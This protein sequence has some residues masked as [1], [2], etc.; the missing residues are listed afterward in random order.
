M[1]E[2]IGGSR[3][4]GVMARLS[5]RISGWLIAHRLLLIAVFAGIT[6]CLGYRA[7]LLHMDPGFDKSIPLKHSYM[8]TFQQYRETFG[9]ANSVVLALLRKDG[10]IFNADYLKTLEDAT[11][12]VI[13][14]PGVDRAWVKSLF[15]PNVF[16]IG[17]NEEGY[18]AGRIVPSDFKP[19]EA[20]IDEVRR[21]LLLSKE[22]G[23]LVSADYSGALISALLVENDPK[24]GEKLDYVRLA[25]QL[26]VIRAKYSND[27][28]SVHIIGFAK[29]IGD[30][31]VG[32]HD[33]FVFFAITLG[34]TAV[35]LYFF[36][37]SVQIT[38]LAITVALVA[39]IWQLGLV[40][41]VGYGVD[42]LSILVPFLIL[43]IGIS[44]AV[45]M[46]NAW[47]L[48]V[49]KG[50][51]SVEA[52][53]EAFNKLFIPGTTAL[54][55]NAVGFGV[56]ML[57]DIAIIHELGI[58]A[59][60]GV[61]VMVITNKFLLPALLCYARINPQSRKTEPQPIARHWQI[62]SGAAERSVWTFV[63]IAVI[64][65]TA[66]W[67]SR[68]LIVGDST[69]GAPEFYADS[70]Y[71]RDVAAINS[72]FNVAIDELMVVAET[73]E[74]GCVDFGVLRTLDDFD[75]E[76]GQVDGV[77]SVQTL[78]RI[79]KE[80]M[81]GNS[82]G[83]WKF[84]AVPRSRYSIGNTIADRS[85][86]VNQQFFSYDC[87]TVPLRIYTADHRAGTLQ[88]IVDAVK[89]FAADQDG[90]DVRFRLASGNAGVMQATNEAV[91][92]AE[93]R[94][95]LALFLAVGLFCYL[96]F[97]SLR[98]VLCIVI[99]LALVAYFANAVM[100]WLGIGLKVSTLPVV[101]LGVGVGVDY[102]IYLFAR[103]YSYMAQGMV[104][105]VAYARALSEVGSAIVF[106]ALTMSL[107][108]AT[109][110]F[111]SLKFQA[112][113]GLLLA[114]MFF[115]NMVG[116]IV[117]LPALAAWFYPEKKESAAIGQAAAVAL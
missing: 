19:T 73:K 100:A 113:M 83:S 104:L 36:C 106:T 47:R 89:R 56:I 27:D 8:E 20:G 107:G 33:V 28:V 65:G 34:I 87:K 42:P 95:N 69:E 68:G 11:R 84:G 22:V 96:T 61:A 23:R 108:I 1:T 9:G 75:W 101:A 110:A 48:E 29:F 21:N 5:E 50:K 115:V 88:G 57:I 94:M 103:A 14:T 7:S 25:E 38:V 90:G 37:R 85:M 52:A 49:A 43:S 46:T 4:M 35:L 82:E 15:T 54:L 64:G 109:W 93:S 63:A 102:G 18:Y 67:G 62:L 58:T 59:S 91:A 55:A 112:D 81:V 39:V 105:R 117:L 72:R 86:N 66:F 79:V 78:S 31:I 53:R 32:A 6:V 99:P 111:A 12:D 3:Y 71:N 98:A 80:R 13:Y 114:Y 97:V 30:V 74:M 70:Q 2:F 10:D 16:F 45:Q 116:A 26:E 60:I 17:V 44:H 41:L 92:A 24:T 51:D 40:Q 77:K 76:I